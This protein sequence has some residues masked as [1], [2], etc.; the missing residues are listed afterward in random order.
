MKESE[1]VKFVEKF[2][3]SNKNIDISMAILPLT[4]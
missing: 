4:L 1:I 2:M 3:K